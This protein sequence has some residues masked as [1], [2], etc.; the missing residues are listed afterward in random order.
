M[1][2]PPAEYQ[3]FL[4]SR[5]DAEGKN[6]A[7]AADVRRHPR[8]AMTRLTLSQRLELMLDHTGR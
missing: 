8:V 2:L 6:T 5:R 3:P 4:F 1:R 7:A